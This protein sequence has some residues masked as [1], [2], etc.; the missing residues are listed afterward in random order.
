MSLKPVQSLLL[1]TSLLLVGHLNGVH[2]KKN[3]MAMQKGYHILLF[4]SA[5]TKSHLNIFRPLAE[6]LLEKGHR[7]TTA[8]YAPSDIKNENYTEI[9]LPDR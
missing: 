6:G 9:L 4:H 2:I 3:S 7:V 5:G 1:L 8:F